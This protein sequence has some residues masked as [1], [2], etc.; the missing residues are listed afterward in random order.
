MNKT[1][2]MSKNI[3]ALPVLPYVDTRGGWM[4]GVTNDVDPMFSFSIRPPE[5]RREGDT[6]SW[7]LGRINENAFEIRDAFFTV[8]SIHDARAFFETYGPWQ[9]KTHLGT[10][11]EAI[12]YSGLIQ[13]RDFFQDALLSRE[14]GVTPTGS[15]AEQWRTFFEDKF[16]WQSLPMEMVFRPPPV[17]IVRCKDAQEAVRAAIFLDRLDGFPWR[18]CAR[19]DCG[20]LFKLKSKRAQLYCDPDCAHLQSVRSYNERKRIEAAKK[21]NKTLRRGRTTRKAGK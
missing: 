17:A 15:I 19:E 2:L 21:K 5:V 3:Y 14:I 20:K 6:E 8:K 18:R 7:S 16:L 1:S 12:R 10:E 9:I 13:Q 4:V 11:A